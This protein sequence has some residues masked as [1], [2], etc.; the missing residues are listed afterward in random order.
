MYYFRCDYRYY[1]LNN[2]CSNFIE[3]EIK[4]AY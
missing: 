2:N 1:W 3:K 4:K